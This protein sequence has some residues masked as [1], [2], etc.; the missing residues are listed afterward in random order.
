VGHLDQIRVLFLLIIW[1]VLRLSLS[2]QETPNLF[3]SHPANGSLPSLQAK[4]DQ[5]NSLMYLQTLRQSRHTRRYI[6][7]VTHAWDRKTPRR[8]L[9]EVFSGEFLS[10]SDGINN[11]TPVLIFLLVLSFATPVQAVNEELTNPHSWDTI[12]IIAA[13]VMSLVATQRRIELLAFLRKTHTNFAILSETWLTGTIEPNIFPGYASI[14]STL[15]AT[16][17]S[18]W[19]VSILFPIEVPLVNSHTPLNPNLRGRYARASF[20]IAGRGTNDLIHIHGIYAPTGSGSRAQREFF[21]DLLLEM[22]EGTYGIDDIHIIGGDLNCNPSEIKEAQA[23]M[24]LFDGTN[25]LLQANPDRHPSTFNTWGRGN[26]TWID[27]IYASPPETVCGARVIQKHGLSCDHDF[28]EVSI[29]LGHTGHNLPKGKTYRTPP[30]FRV[31]ESDKEGKRKFHALT[32]N[33]MRKTPE[34]TTWYSGVMTREQLQTLGEIEFEK[35]ADLFNHLCTD[36]AAEFFSTKTRATRYDRKGRVIFLKGSWGGNLVNQ[37]SWIRRAK[38]HFREVETSGW[39]QGKNRQFLLN[40]AMSPV[41]P[42]NLKLDPSGY[43]EIGS[44]TDWHVKANATR[45]KIS[46]ELKKEVRSVA[47]SIR[48]EREKNKMTETCKNTKAFRRMVYPAGENTN[49]PSHVEDALGCL[50]TSPEEVIQVYHDYAAKLYNNPEPDPD[51]PRPWTNLSIWD[52]Y[53]KQTKKACR[54]AGPL[55]RCATLHEL[56]NFLGKKKDTSP[57]LD[58]IQY[59]VI[60]TLPHE[61]RQLLLNIVNWS[62]TKGTIPTRLKSAEMVFFWKGKG[63]RSN[64][65]QYRG[66]TL[67]MVPYKCI[68]GIVTKRKGLLRQSMPIFNTGQGG[69]IPGRSVGTKAYIINNV[70]S[71]CKRHNKPVS[72][73]WFDLVKGYDL[74]TKRAISDSVDCLGWGDDYKNFLLSTMTQFRARAR[75]PYGTTEAFDYLNGVKQGDPASPDIYDDWMEMLY[76]WAEEK[77]LHF[78]MRL[79]PLVPSS[80][81][82]GSSIKI[83]PQGW[84]DDFGIVVKPSRAQKGVNLV[85][86]FAKSYNA[87]VS[88][89]TE[90]LAVGWEPGGDL[91]LDNKVIKWNNK[92]KRLRVL[93]YHFNDQDTWD[94]H[95]EIL[96]L[97]TERRLARVAAAQTTIDGR[98]NLIN[99]DILGLVLFPTDIIPLPN[100]LANSIQQLCKKAL[101]RGKIDTSISAALTI[102]T[103]WNWRGIEDIQRTAK[104]RLGGIRKA[105]QADDPTAQVSTMFTAWEASHTIC[106]G[107]DCLAFPKLKPRSKK[108]KD[109]PD[110]LAAT[111][112]ILAETGMNI[113]RP[114][115]RHETKYVLSMANL[116]GINITPSTKNLLNAIE[117]CDCTTTTTS[118]IKIDKRKINNLGMKKGET[119]RVQTL[120]KTVLNAW[121]SDPGLRSHKKSALEVIKEVIGDKNE[122]SEDQIVATDGSFYPTNPG[123]G[124]AGAVVSFTGLLI[125]FVMPNTPSNEAAEL[126]AI[127]LAILVTKPRV[128]LTIHSDSQ[129][130]TKLVDKAIQGRWYDS[131]YK[132][133]NFPQLV[134]AVM[135]ASRSRQGTTKISYVPAHTKN[136]DYASNLNRVADIFAK[137]AFNSDSAILPPEFHRGINPTGQ[138]ATAKP[139]H[140]LAENGRPTIGSWYRVTLSALTEQPTSAELTEQSLRP[141]E[142]PFKSEIFSQE[143]SWPVLRSKHAKEKK[144]IFLLKI[145]SRSLPVCRRLSLLYPRLYN[146][147]ACPRCGHHSEDLE[148]ALLTCPHNQRINQHL[149]EKIQL[150]LKLDGLYWPTVTLCEATNN[151]GMTAG[152]LSGGIPNWV[153][154]ELRY[155]YGKKGAKIA[156][157]ISDTILEARLEAWE[158]R[159]KSWEPPFPDFG[160]AREV[161]EEEYHLQQLETLEDTMLK[162]RY[163]DVD[164]EL[165]AAFGVF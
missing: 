9:L 152:Y 99:S 53:R 108:W 118:G 18:K 109:F 51:I 5:I 142:I 21:R 38:K 102:K 111:R 43:P 10:L 88:T 153:E 6:G 14:H 42:H 120:T 77:K 132:K 106:E 92:P 121:P 158:D 115:L 146:S 52:E 86:N 124:C 136:S 139:V 130:N 84:I 87:Q 117:M 126:M 127:L 63:Q 56:Q 137:N 16:S 33:E 89:K 85:N 45:Q 58:R 83:R 140:F 22:G 67:L 35:A 68:M 71:F 49:S 65:T 147:Q 112:L 165:I 145:L 54:K 50:H 40:F 26:R 110:Y 82:F 72:L 61:G 98:A 96:T 105:L 62:L 24:T 91:K 25:A 57:G 31:H 37:L 12:S 123:R 32:I 93:G 95:L 143:C 41:A 122:S 80:P 48:T 156:T 7:G 141:T 103:K 149:K 133:S 28:V 70:I 164:E 66:I 34:L 8:N 138:V 76:R 160:R 101:I 27:H 94:D 15:P 119:K 134:E 148:H 64:L 60:K 113:I 125:D 131:S 150:R 157:Q 20:R 3:T 44:W 162:S 17:S 144:Y 100:T 2:P 163:E 19:G 128:N 75:T 73:I 135:E 46:N 36:V 151:R 29:H 159:N 47:R 155:I 13:N 107:S 81:F 104:A 11:L 39:P 23:C 116:L 90:A 1:E 161:D 4:I 74:V 69:G 129:S 114:A 78:R 154:E 97:E 55:L 30:K 59:A 79:P